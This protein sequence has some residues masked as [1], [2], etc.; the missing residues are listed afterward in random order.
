V[1]GAEFHARAIQRLANVE[2]VGIADLDES[3]ARELAAHHGGPP[4]FPSLDELLTTNPDVVHVLTPPSAHVGNVV[5]VDHLRSQHYPHFTGGRLPEL[6]RDGGY[7]FRDIGVHSLYLLESFLGP[8]RDLDARLGSPETDGYPRFK[9]WRV[10]VECER[11]LG[12]VYLWWNVRPLQ[13]LLIIHGTRGVIRCDIFGMAVTARCQTRLPEKAERIANTALEGCRM[14]TQVTG[15]VLRF[16]TKR[17]R[18]YHGLQALVG[19]FYTSLAEGKPA[20]VNLDDARRLLRWT[21]EVAGRADEAKRRYESRFAK[22]GTAKVLVT[23]ATGFIGRHL[24]ERL[25][26]ERDQVR[27]QVRRTPVVSCQLSVNNRR[28]HHLSAIN[29][30]LSTVN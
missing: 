18:H 4:V 10:S 20:P 22:T 9:E 23:G 26:K 1:A 5:A 8:I 19:E 7:P 30:Q 6:F 24:L 14:A 11:G 25:L 13:D 29:C 3:R 15:S 2:L 21:E 28:R 12:Q 17:L 16:L 27:I